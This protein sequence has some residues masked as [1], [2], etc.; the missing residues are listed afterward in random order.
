ML[1]RVLSCK[2][3]YWAKEKAAQF[4]S[5]DCIFSSITF[6]LIVC[7]ESRFNLREGDIASNFSSWSFPKVISLANYWARE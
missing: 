5:K 1:K 7:R 3:Y 2:I 4:L 6:L